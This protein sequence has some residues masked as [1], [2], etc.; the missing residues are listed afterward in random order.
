MLLVKSLMLLL[1]GVN[2]MVA[3]I[4]NPDPLS[5]LFYYFTYWG[6]VTSTFATFFTIKAATQPQKF[7]TPAMVFSQTA[8][9]YNLFITPCFWIVLAPPLFK[10]LDY[11][12]W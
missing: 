9:A 3:L 10:S 12:I 4:L 5:H 1:L 7:Q 11:S 2:L 8:L 6:L